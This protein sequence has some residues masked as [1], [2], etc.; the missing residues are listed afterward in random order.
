[1]QEECYLPVLHAYRVLFDFINSKPYFGMH[2][3]YPIFFS[4]YITAAETKHYYTL[5]KQIIYYHQVFEALRL[6]NICL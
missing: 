2:N 1:M 4:G 5:D 6:Q 3:L